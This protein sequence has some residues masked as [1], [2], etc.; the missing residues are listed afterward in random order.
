MLLK[1]PAV[2]A[3]P[4]GRIGRGIQGRHKVLQGDLQR[5]ADVDL[6]ARRARRDAEPTTTDGPSEASVIVNV[7]PRS[8]G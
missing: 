8:P 7:P 2:A 6:I 5:R 1:G 4:D 3:Q